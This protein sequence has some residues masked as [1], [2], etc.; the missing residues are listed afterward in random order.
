MSYTIY[1]A[2]KSIEAELE[3]KGDNWNNKVFDMERR[4]FN[5]IVEIRK[6]N[7]KTSYFDLKEN[8][9][10]LKAQKFEE[11]LENIKEWVMKTDD[12]YD[13]NTWTES[14]EI[15][16]AKKVRLIKERREA[17]NERAR[18]RILRRG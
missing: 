9:A 8:W 5:Q 1:K 2:I 4:C 18:Q 3:E 13:G 14:F 17:R 6:F 10:L 11:V 12:R 7:R 15:R 16:D